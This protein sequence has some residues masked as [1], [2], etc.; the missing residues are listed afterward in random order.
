MQAQWVGAPAHLARLC[1]SKLAAGLLR[2]A[3][4]VCGLGYV[5]RCV[6]TY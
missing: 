5:P 1:V 3:I 6:G 4:G 2:N